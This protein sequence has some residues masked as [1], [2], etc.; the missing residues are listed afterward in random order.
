MKK[1]LIV[2]LLAVIGLSFSNNLSYAQDTAKH[3]LH[4]SEVLVGKAG[5]DPEADPREGRFVYFLIGDSIYDH[6]FVG[7]MNNLIED[8][9]L[10][11]SSFFADLI[12][13]GITFM[14]LPNGL[15]RNIYFYLEKSLIDGVEEGVAVSHI[16]RTYLAY[17]QKPEWTGFLWQ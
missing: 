16:V 3:Q 7:F 9:L 10:T 15:D 6:K 17:R 12:I 1:E 13:S 8:S 5:F 2:I 11:E 14:P 4:L